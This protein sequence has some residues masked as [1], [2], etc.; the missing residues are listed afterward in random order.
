[1]ERDGEGMGDRATRRPKRRGRAARAIM[2]SA[3]ARWSRVSKMAVRFENA[4]S[5]GVGAIVVR[6]TNEAAATRAREA[7]ASERER[8]SL[9]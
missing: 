5:A 3:R 6:G 9:R 2:R 8:E 7:R 1:M 4:R